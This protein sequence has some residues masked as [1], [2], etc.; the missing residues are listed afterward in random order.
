MILV[1]TRLRLNSNALGTIR[2]LKTWLQ[3]FRGPVARV[4]DPRYN[5]PSAQTV[6]LSG[7]K[8]CQYLN[9]LTLSPV[10]TPEKS[11]DLIFNPITTVSLFPNP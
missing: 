3:I 4:N 11:A 8:M 10:L 2:G 5:S 7:I 9:A 6:T 1:T